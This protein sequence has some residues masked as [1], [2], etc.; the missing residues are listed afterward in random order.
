MRLP[1]LSALNVCSPDF[2]YWVSDANVDCDGALERGACAAD[3]SHQSDTQWHVDGKP[4]DAATVP[5]VVINLDDD[6]RP[7]DFGIVGV[8][9]VAVLCAGQLRFAILGDSN[10]L[11]QQGEMS[12]K[13]AQQVRRPR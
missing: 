13:L 5:Y 12:V 6:F 10:P 8:S 11:G 9:A 1:C 7:S 3:P 4:I 2:V